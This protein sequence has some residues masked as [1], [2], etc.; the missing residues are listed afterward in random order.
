MT[1]LRSQLAKPA[2]DSGRFGACALCFGFFMWEEESER[3]PL[4][5]CFVHSAP[6]RPALPA[7]GTARSS[8][9]IAPFGAGTIRST[10]VQ[11][12]ARLG[13]DPPTEAPY[14]SVVPLQPPPRN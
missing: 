6:H 10:N 2:G 12:L 5:H 9:T 8:S 1:H 3:V 14:S 4:K 13:P 7:P 11:R